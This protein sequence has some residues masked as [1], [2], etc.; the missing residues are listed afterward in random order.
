VNCACAREDALGCV[1]GVPQGDDSMKTITLIYGDGI[2]KEVISSAK[3]IVEASGA[4][5]DWEVQRQVQRL[6]TSMASQ[7][8]MLCWKVLRVMEW[9]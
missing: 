7:L 2:G 4:N 8:M 5:V 1:F 9:H 3:A 6:V